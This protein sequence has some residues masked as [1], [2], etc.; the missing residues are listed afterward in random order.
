MP[1][2][3]LFKKNRQ[4]LEQ[5]HYE[6]QNKY[7]VN[8]KDMVKEP[9]FDY[10]PECYDRNYPRP[11]NM[12]S[13]AVLEDGVVFTRDVKDYL[14]RDL[15]K[16]VIF[17]DAP[18]P[19]G[20]KLVD[21]S[22]EQDRSILGWN[23][24]IGDDLCLVVSTGEKGKGIEFNRACNMMFAGFFELE[25]LEWN[26]VITTREMR[27]MRDMFDGCKSLRNVDLRDFDVSN[28]KYM[29]GLFSACK[30]LENIK[31]FRFNTANVEDV[32]YMFTNCHNLRS[33]NLSGF[34][35]S[36][37]KSCKKMFNKCGVKAVNLGNWASTSP[38]QELNAEG[39]FDTTGLLSMLT[40]SN[41][42]VQREYLNMD[43]A[44][45][46]CQEENNIPRK[47]VPVS[48]WK[49]PTYAWEK[50]PPSRGES[51]SR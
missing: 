26:N 35:A 7:D 5:N 24:T 14:L 47:I 2:F 42:I 40:T 22:L 23:Q 19:E 44:T 1:I 37:L 36:S 46:E 9:E 3:E 12:S 41:P 27:S 11:Y 39:M 34:D 8:N 21:L 30:K 45:R 10:L 31:W 33:V 38:T 25:S 49:V 28:V 17:T 32:S 4:G 18:F 51:L 48:E 16:R 20:Y 6:N 13:Y 50:M 43:E 29:N 15:V